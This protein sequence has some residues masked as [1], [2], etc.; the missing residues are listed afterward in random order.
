MLLLHRKTTGQ[1]LLGD[2]LKDTRLK[3]IAT[4]YISKLDP[5]LVY[6]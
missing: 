4:E 1:D 6:V 2:I 5:K 3:N